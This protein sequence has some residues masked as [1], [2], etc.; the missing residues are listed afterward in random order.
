MN[1]RK[2]EKEERK[3]VKVDK[4]S[5]GNRVERKQEAES[6]RDREESKR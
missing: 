2:G 5:E 1:K 4:M 6:K 3:P